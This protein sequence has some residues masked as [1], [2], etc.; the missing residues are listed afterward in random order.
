MV[1]KKIFSRNVALKRILKFLVLFDQKK[2]VRLFIAIFLQ[3]A[4]GLLDLIGVGAISLIGAISLNGIKS[5][6]PGK[7]SL[8]ALNLLHLNSLEFHKQIF[9]IGMIVSILL[10]LR[11]LISISISK[12]LLGFLSREGVRISD[13]ALIK[14]F[15]QDISTFR[16]MDLQ[17]SIF[18]LTNGTTAISVG[19][20]G[21]AII[22]ISDLSL[23]TFISIGFFFL[24]PATALTALLIFSFIGYLI[25]KYSSSQALFLGRENRKISINQNSQI[26][27]MSLF[28]RENHVKNTWR[29]KLRQLSKSR[30]S[31]AKNQADLALLP[32]YGKY[33]IES[34]LIISA[35]VMAAIQ[36]SL[37]DSVHAFAALTMFLAAA[38]RIAPAVLR[39]QQGL[40]QI[41]NSLTMAEATLFQILDL[42]RLPQN[43]LI[44]FE[45]SEVK[46]SIFLPSIKFTNVD[47]RFPD[48]NRNLFTDLNFQI[49]EFTQIGIIGSSGEG[50]STLIDL[51]L[52][53]LRPTS[54]KIEIS[55]KTPSEIIEEFGYEISFVPQENPLLDG[56]ILENIFYN[57]EKMNLT[58]EEIEK[59]LNTTN[60]RSFIDSLD[61]G[62]ETRLGVSGQQLS[63]GQRQK[64]A[65]ARAIICKPKLIV[66]DEPTS[67]LD[68]MSSME[69]VETLAKLKGHAT[70]VII[71]H[72]LETLK[73]A[74]RILKLEKGDVIELD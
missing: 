65:M 69:I 57:Q 42:N 15:E 23:T 62:L 44:K 66:L 39:I 49:S 10:V 19:V 3:L 12:K 72:D 29:D 13:S 36:L 30:Y 2:R 60:L 64:I 51:L 53:L 63:G 35:F 25:A 41:N 7:I 14:L 34:G 5:S 47:F 11:T 70:V 52:G 26:L 20:L 73:Y 18:N 31:L 22:M 74:D 16:K 32:N 58:V 56:T 61:Y 55:G 43:S 67:S 45:K 71:S 17:E 24:F 54:G 46:M 21:N 48:E 27:Q 1:T 40:I 59:C 28:F 38:S 68:A 37:T 33:I 8:E 6:P 9:Y 4:I 50:K